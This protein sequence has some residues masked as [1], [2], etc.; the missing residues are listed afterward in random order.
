MGN[1]EGMRITSVPFHVT[2]TL[3]MKAARAETTPWAYDVG[4]SAAV[5]DGAS[6]ARSFVL[7]LGASNKIGGRVPSNRW[8]P[9]DIGLSGAVW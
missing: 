3:P 4:P 1:E 5:A 2:L 8:L 9:C 7:T 6:K